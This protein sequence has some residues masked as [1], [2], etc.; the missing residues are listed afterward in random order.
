VET[1]VSLTV[2]QIQEFKEIDHLRTQGMQ[3]AEKHCRKLK[4][5]EVAWS[6]VLADC[7]S[8]IDFWPALVKVCSGKKVSSRLIHRLMRKAHLEGVTNISLSAAKLNL[9]Q[10]LQRYHLLK[11]QLVQ[12]HKS[13]LESLACVQ[14][15]ERGLSV[16][17]HLKTLWH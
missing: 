11:K 6:P 13:F 5:G 14:A 15:E 4:M 17:K 9:K 12:L 7:H 16:M 2:E 8:K 1:G 10:E 3:L